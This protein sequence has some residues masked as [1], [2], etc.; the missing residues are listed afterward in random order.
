MFATTWALGLERQ[1]LLPVVTAGLGRSV[2]GTG[3]PLIAPA[4]CA[5][6]ERS[7]IRTHAPNK[8]RNQGEDAAEVQWGMFRIC[9][10]TTKDATSTQ[11]SRAGALTLAVLEA[12]APVTS[13]RTRRRPQTRGRAAGPMTDSSNAVSLLTDLQKQCVRAPMA[14]GKTLLATAPA[15][16]QHPYFPRP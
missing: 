7:F 4:A 2:S 11:W 5:G 3:R 10:R 15:P 1:S 14:Q 8:S 12:R 16:K 6:R 13:A 9:E